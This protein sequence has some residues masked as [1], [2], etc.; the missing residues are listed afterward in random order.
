MMPLKQKL[1]SIT[2]IFFLLFSPTFAFARGLVPCGGYEDDAGT[3]REPI[4]TVEHLFIMI[5][6]VTNWLISMV[7]VYATYI[8]I[9]TGFFLAIAQ[10]DEEKLSTQ[11]KRLT[12]AVLGFALVLMA[13]M[14]VNTIVN[15]LL[16][17]Q[18]PNHKVDLTKP[19]CYLSNTRPECIVPR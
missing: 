11:K 6:R 16:A 17:R 10:G 4:C 9:S 3:V 14:F 19:L 13:F 18:Q 8:L 1:L 2:F 7:G 5:A 15:Y 12:N